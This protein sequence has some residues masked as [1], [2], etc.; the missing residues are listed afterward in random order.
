LL[1]SSIF[2]I[3]GALSSI[4]AWLKARLEKDRPVKPFEDELDQ[5]YEALYGMTLQVTEA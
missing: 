5:D 1:A 2:A 4:S 3:V